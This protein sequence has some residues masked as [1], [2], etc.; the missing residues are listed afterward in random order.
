MWAGGR[1]F[2]IANPPDMNCNGLSRWKSDVRSLEKL[3]KMRESKGIYDCVSV[4]TFSITIRFELNRNG[5]NMNLLR[6]GN[7]DCNTHRK[8]WKFVCVSARTS[9]YSGCENICCIGSQ[10]YSDW[11]NIWRTVKDWPSYFWGWPKFQGLQRCPEDILIS[12][13]SVQNLGRPLKYVN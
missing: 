3:E 5:I 9:G 11:M 4:W 13:N 12:P 7:N 1:L 8:F 10:Y 6:N 2:A